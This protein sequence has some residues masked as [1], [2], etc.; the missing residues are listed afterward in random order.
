MA[1][2]SLFDFAGLAFGGYSLL[3]SRKRAAELSEGMNKQYAN[4]QEYQN[5]LLGVMGQREQSS[6]AFQGEMAELARQ[7]GEDMQGNQL[8]PETVARINGLVDF[9]VGGGQAANLA[10][11]KPQ[12]EALEGALKGQ[13]VG[14]DNDHGARMFTIANN[15][16][17]EAKIRAL[18]NLDKETTDKKEQIRQQYLT[19]VANLN[20]KLTDQYT[21]WALGSKD[22]DTATK[23]ETF[24]TVGSIATAGKPSA[25]DYS[26]IGYERAHADPMKYLYLDSAG[27]GKTTSDTSGNIM[28]LIG[29]VANRDAQKPIAERQEV[30]KTPQ[31]TIGVGNTS[32]TP[33]SKDPF[34]DV[35]LWDIIK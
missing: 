13:M 25:A 3:E 14:I 19:D 18:M 23:L 10:I 29:N 12:F 11:L 30:L 33:V 7:V 28:K 15:L 34:K 24:K 16:T 31:P 22:K 27:T 6:Q 20:I 32:A 26:V 1:Q 9:F 35:D 5:A 21:Q 8:P 4:N 2:L 17:G